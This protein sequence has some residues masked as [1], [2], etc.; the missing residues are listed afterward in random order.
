MKLLGSALLALA[1]LGFQE[2]F[3]RATTD[4]V[5]V[6]VSVTQGGTPVTD[7]AVEQ[8]AVFDNGV[9]QHIESFQV[10]RGSH[11]ILVADTSSSLGPGDR[12]E[13][14]RAV[15]S[16]VER[17]AGTDRLS[18]ISFDDD[19][20]VHAVA[21]S[22]SLQAIRSLKD[23]R[24]GRLTALHDALMLAA[25]LVGVDD[26]P[27]LVLLC[28]D[29]GDTASWTPALRVIHTVHAA[30][31]V[32]YAVGMG[33]GNPLS[34]RSDTVE[35]P[36]F[37]SSTWLAAS[38]DDAPAILKR[39][40]DETGGRYSSIRDVKQLERTFARM[41]EERRHRYVLAYA[42]AEVGQQDGWH[43]IAVKLRNARG[44]VTAR[45]GYYAR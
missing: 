45:R 10:S 21:V 15:E 20:R 42:P 28:T 14:L 31:V 33:I 3:F 17:M 32:L 2:P 7:L 40:A 37:T 1:Y 19:V 29:G 24:G 23:V 27:P 13:L 4:L 34:A 8:F 43:D 41:L 18:L 39:L 11:V 6:D 25:G 5:I 38:A 44:E 26:R 30:N 22:P 35:S 9:E 16:V 36:F 12:V